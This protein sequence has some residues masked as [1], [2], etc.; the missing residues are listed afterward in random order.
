LIINQSLAHLTHICFHSMDHILGFLVE[1]IPWSKIR[2]CKPLVLLKMAVMLFL[3][4]MGV[5]W[6]LIIG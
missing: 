1:T 3:T 4:K 5:A 2:R 6:P